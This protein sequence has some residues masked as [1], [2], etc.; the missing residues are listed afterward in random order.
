MNETSCERVLRPNRWKVLVL[1]AVSL[2]F[3]AIGVGMAADGR[4]MGWVAVGFFGLG[5]VVFTVQLL[6]GSAS[7]RLGPDGFVIC[8][9]F[10]PSTCRWSDVAR[11]GVGTVG[12]KRMVVFDFAPNARGSVALRRLATALSGWEGALPDCYGMSAEEL[13]ALL[14][15]YKEAAGRL[16]NP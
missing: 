4:W 12:P 15:A 3:T 9:L 16:H 11:F 2:V 6:P 5:V 10:R 13:A 8:S 7:L 14:N 1:L